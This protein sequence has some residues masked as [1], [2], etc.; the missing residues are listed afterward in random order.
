MVYVI[1]TSKLKDDLVM[2]EREIERM[3]NA[4]TDLNQRNDALV[5]ENG[6][7]KRSIEDYKE[8]DDIVSQLVDEQRQLKQ[9]LDTVGAIN[10][11]KTLRIG[12]LEKELT[13]I[14]TEQTTLT[15]EHALVEAKTQDLTQE[16]NDLRASVATLTNDLMDEKTKFV[17]TMMMSQR[18][19]S[20]VQI[21]SY[22]PDNLRPSDL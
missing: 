3:G 21:K 4:I 18:S 9:Q 14:R 13:R 20:T 10:D 5:V 2:L 11:Q 12:S 19:S 22:P 17:N 6:Q 8:R 16:N 15:R 7:L 1:M